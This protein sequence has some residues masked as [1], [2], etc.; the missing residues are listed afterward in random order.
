MSLIRRYPKYCSKKLESELND[1]DTPLSSDNMTNLYN[2]QNAY[3][4]IVN[5]EHYNKSSI[6]KNLITL[7]RYLKLASNNP[8]LTYN[9]PIGIGEPTIKLIITKEELIKFVKFLNTKHLYVII[10]I[11]M[12]MYKFW[13]RIGALA[14]IKVNGKDADPL[15]TYLKSQK[16]GVMGKNIKWNFTKFLVD[17]EGNVV[18]RYAPTTKPEEF[19]EKIV[20]LLKK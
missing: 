16:G 20:E 9:L 15:Y 5:N 7:L 13:L 19:E 2:P 18:E 3:D 4:F 11:C 1:L 6:K 12:L 8:F 17:R 14:K 10:I